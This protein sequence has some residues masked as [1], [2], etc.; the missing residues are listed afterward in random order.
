MVWGHGERISRDRRLF[1]SRLG[2]GQKLE[3]LGPQESRAEVSSSLPPSQAWDVLSGLSGGCKMKCSTAERICS[4]TMTLTCEKHA[5]RD[6][7]HAVGQLEA[8]YR[9]ICPC[10]GFPPVDEPPIPRTK[11]AR[12]AELQ[13]TQPTQNTQPIK[14]TKTE[15]AENPES[16]GV[17][18]RVRVHGVSGYRT[19]GCRCEVCVEAMRA[20]RRK[21]RKKSDSCRIRFSPEPLIERLERDERMTAVSSSVIHRWRRDGLDVYGVDRWCIKLGYHPTEIYGQ[22]FYAGIDL[23]EVA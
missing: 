1:L 16:S 12:A 6:V 8:H 13:P 21:Y 5:R 3:T 11:K 14:A 19:W 22:D 10:H 2:D 15:S 4:S 18:D 23:D 9:G 17:A 7:V 20:D